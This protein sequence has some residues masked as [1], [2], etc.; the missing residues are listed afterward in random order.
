[1][2]DQETELRRK[3]GARLSQA[4]VR[5]GFVSQKDARD[6]LGLGNTDIVGMWERGDTMPR[7]DN[8]AALCRI[9]RVSADWVLGLSEN[10]QISGDGAIVNLEVERAI[11][12]S[13]S[14]S[15]LLQ[16]ARDMNAVA[17]GIVFGYPIPRE[18][19]VIVEAEWTPRR[20]ALSRK[21][22]RLADSEA[23]AA[24]KS[25]ERARDAPNGSK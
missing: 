23:K 25:K 2:A 11:L 17:D 14:L 1:M 6:A 18:Y 19:E 20:E 24:K 8:L 12:R 10:P 22:Q 4:R 21:L 9:Y 15:E 5:A 16:E 7:A 13:T 3:V